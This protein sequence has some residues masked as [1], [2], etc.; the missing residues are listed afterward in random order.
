MGYAEEANTA[1]YLT[2]LEGAW[3]VIND[4]AQ[5]EQTLLGPLDAA[6]RMWEA[7][8]TAIDHVLADFP[9]V[10]GELLAAWTSPA[11]SGEYKLA[12]DETQGALQTSRN[13]IAEV[14][15]LLAQLIPLISQADQASK[16]ARTEI[17]R[18]LKLLADWKAA[19]PFATLDQ[20]LTQDALIT[21]QVRGPVVDAGNALNRLANWYAYTG[22]GI[23]A[24][25]Q[26]L[27]WL[28][29]GS[30]NSVPIRG[31]RT[32]SPGGPGSTPNGA[33][34]S[35][36][37]G[38]E[39]G[40]EQAGAGGGA[41]GGQQAGGDAGA[42]VP[43][44]GAAGEVPGGTGGPG[45]A[46]LPTVP[47]AT[48]PNIPVQPPNIATPTPP[49]ATPIGTLPVGG[50]PLGPPAQPKGGG[51]IG[52]GGGFGGG[53]GGGGFGGGGVGGGGG[54]KTPEKSGLN[55][56]GAGERQIPRAGEQVTQPQPLS[57]GRPPATTGGATV[58]GSSPAGTGAGG[59]PPMMP[60][61]GMAPGTGGG[62]RAGKP[63]AGTV[64]PVG[65]KRDRQQ[66]DTPGIPAGLRGKAGRELPGAFP[67]APASTRRRH[68]D[69]AET[70]QLLDEELWKVEETTV[71]PAAQPRRL[72]N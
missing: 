37:G 29:P 47:V 62:N 57:G 36:S 1:R 23:V 16:T 21:D 24:A 33:D 41:G 2:S 35:A 72:A 38:P 4:Y 56:P 67:T 54:I 40:A 53:G 10:N 32:A 22:S 64:R 59:V 51:R 61:G 13:S 68:E 44:G 9:T 18:G 63:G 7:A 12:V 30:G 19:N 31:S 20:I 46:G 34:M 15:K 52:G 71:A 48:P 17:D 3:I 60:P 25:G 65:R 55:L 69:E 58:G 43:P 5:S 27:K 70:L 8:G 6:K 28:G 39:G 49:G 66:G 11:D 26:G 50:L 42:G 14:P 45:L